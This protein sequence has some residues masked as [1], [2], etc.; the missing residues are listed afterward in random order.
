M[1]IARVL[2]VLLAFAPLPALAQA[3]NHGPSNGG[4]LLKIGAYEG[5]L[6]VRG[7][8]VTLYVED[9]KERKADASKLSATVV[10]LA[11]GNE[12]KTIELT[13]GG[14]NKLV[15]KVDFPFEGKFRATVTLRSASGE[16]GKGRYSLDPIR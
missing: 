14:D 1:H 12:Q 2:A 16:I 4:Q 10:V 8:D 9:D 6:V 5:E 15:G 7:S 3:H 13:P 11:R